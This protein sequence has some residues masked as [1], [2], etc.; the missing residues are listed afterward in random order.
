MWKFLAPKDPLSDHM[1]ATY[2]S[3]R[4]G[5]VV[6]SFF[7]P[8]LLWWGGASVGIPLQDSMSDYYFAERPGR[9]DAFP[10][11]TWFVGLLF[12]IGA[13]L[14]LYKG[15]TDEENGVLN[16]AGICAWLVAVFPTD[17]EA[18]A[19]AA[20]G[21][22]A[23]ELSVHG[24]SAV[25]LFLCLA[26]VAWRCAC[27]TLKLLPPDHKHLEPLFRQLYK[28]CA[29]L[30]VVLPLAAFG[31]GLVANLKQDVF[32]AEALG[33]WVF[34]AYWWIK[35]RE[36]SL[37]RAQERAAKGELD[38]T[39]STGAG[40]AAPPPQAAQPMHAADWLGLLVVLFGKGRI[41]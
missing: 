27:S 6:F 31:L 7:F 3:V 13:F 5:M 35:H 30:M 19:P 9:P 8:L 1:R 10:L 34:A 33:I 4:R 23:S 32:W 15:F 21:V 25:L 36:L 24:T 20:P 39:M 2:F 11:R 41:R 38:Q 28:G 26:W 18:Q 16:L 37:S 17:R 40:A 29:V 12:A 22:S 14:W